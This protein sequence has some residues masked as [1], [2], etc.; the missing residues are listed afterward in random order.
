MENTFPGIGIQKVK[1]IFQYHKPTVE[2]R[3]LYIRAYGYFRYLLSTIFKTTKVSWATQFFNVVYV[4]KSYYL[5]N[6]KFLVIE[7][8][9]RE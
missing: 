3:S 7:R 5:F 2:Q 4:K 6:V 1:F 8:T 9:V